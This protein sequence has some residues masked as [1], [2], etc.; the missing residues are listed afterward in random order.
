MNTKLSSAA[1][2]LALVGYSCSPRLGPSVPD[3]GAMRMGVRFGERLSDARR[4]RPEMQFVPYSGW[5]ERPSGPGLA[6]IDFRFGSGIPGA[7]PA[8]FSGMHRLTSVW[9]FADSGTT[10]SRMLQVFTLVE[11]R[12]GPAGCLSGG[13]NWLETQVLS[14]VSDSVTWWMLIPVRIDRGT[15]TRGTPVVGVAPTGAD[16]QE[17]LRS[18]MVPC[19][20]VARDTATGH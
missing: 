1:L 10:V 8:R 16:A 6:S 7:A 20:A 15:V 14:S 4:A 17:L 13:G 11:G 12:F 2:S 18:P 3:V 19:A 5:I 9:F